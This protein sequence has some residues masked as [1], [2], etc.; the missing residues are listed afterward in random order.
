MREYVRLG[1]ALLSFAAIGSRTPMLLV[2][3]YG[4][5]HDC[6]IPKVAA[7]SALCSAILGELAAWPVMPAV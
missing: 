2:S 7:T 3:V 4:W 6:G 5:A 1:R